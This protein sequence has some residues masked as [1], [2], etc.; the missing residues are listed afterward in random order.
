MVSFLCCSSACMPPILAT[1]LFKATRSSRH[2]CWSS[3]QRLRSFCQRRRSSSCAAKAWACSCWSA[4]SAA[5]CAR[6]LAAA[7]SSAR[8]SAARA[9]SCW[10]CAAARSDASSFCRAPMR[11]RSGFATS[12]VN[13]PHE[14]VC[15]LE[16]AVCV[17]DVATVVGAA[18]AGRGKLGRSRV[19]GFGLMHLVLRLDASMRLMGLHSCCDFRGG[20]AG[21]PPPISI[22]PAPAGTRGPRHA[23]AARRAGGLGDAPPTGLG[24][25]EAT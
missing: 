7:A 2:C 9:S 4:S 22:A 25:P 24:R 14:A 11:A 6:P 21:R 5:W 8:A 23:A 10:P 15:A 17:L 12:A 1:S 16:E 13:T 19:G 20:A 3:N 18:A